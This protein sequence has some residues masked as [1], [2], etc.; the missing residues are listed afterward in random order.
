MTK[1]PLKVIVGQ[2]HICCIRL[3]SI[4]IGFQVRYSETSRSAE[5]Q[6]ISSIQ[7]ESISKSLSTLHRYGS[8][9]RPI[10]QYL[11]VLHAC[12]AH[13]LYCILNSVC[14]YTHT[15]TTYVYATNPAPQYYI[16]CCHTFNINIHRTN[17]LFF[18]R[19]CQGIYR[20]CICV[21]VQH[22]TVQTRYTIVK[23]YY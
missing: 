7:T 10:R 12:I 9:V 17:V 2:M 8:S 4:F 5:W 18:C 19:F 15:H 16:H 6:N 20:L 13:M 23:F 11:S 21:Y 3:L 14:V 1:L 22:T